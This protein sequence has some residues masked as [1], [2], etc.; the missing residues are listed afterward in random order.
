VN[1]HSIYN[2]SKYFVDSPLQADPEAVIQ[3]FDKLFP[4]NISE[5][6]KEDLQAFVNRSFYE[7]TNELIVCEPDD[8]TEKPAKI[9]QIQ[10]VEVE[11]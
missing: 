5:I 1:Y 2:D 4:M 10:D 11:S 9:M 8:W 6:K 7:P 3:E